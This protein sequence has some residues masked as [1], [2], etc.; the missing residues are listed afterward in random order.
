MQITICIRGLY[1]MVHCVLITNLLTAHVVLY[2][3]EN[4]NKYNAYLQNMFKIY[5]TIYVVFLK[6][7]GN[8]LN[9]QSA[10][11]AHDAIL[12]GPYEKLI[13]YIKIA[14][15]YLIVFFY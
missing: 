6:G 15:F 13:I 7:T 8:D 3:M 1:A 14:F 12:F 2:Y 9:Q 10:T 5:C 4:M 11:L